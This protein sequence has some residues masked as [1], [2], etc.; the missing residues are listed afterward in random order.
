MAKGFLDGYKTYDTTEGFGSI[1]DWQKAF[2]Q[3]MGKEEAE[4]ILQDGKESPHDILG[5]AIGATKAEIK[6]AF[7]KLITQWHPDHNE[8]NITE[9]EERSKKIIAA[10]TILNNKK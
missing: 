4:S 3:R 8:S 1:N 5:I 6:T 9:A 2:N 10:Y 7:R